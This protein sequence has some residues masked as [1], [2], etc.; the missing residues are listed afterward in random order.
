MTDTY[1]KGAQAVVGFAPET[2]W[3][4]AGTAF[5]KFGIPV[6]TITPT[7]TATVK[8]LNDMNSSR[9]GTAQT[10]T[11]Y[12]YEIT[13]SFYVNDY[14]GLLG[15]LGNVTKTGSSPF[16]YS[17]TPDD[18]CIPSFSLYNK[19][20]N[21]DVSKVITDIYVGCKI[22]TAN[23]SIN[24]GLLMCDLTF[25]AKDRLADQGEKVITENTAEIYKYADIVNGVI[26]IDSND[27]QID[28]W[29]ISIDNKIVERQAGLTI[30]E[31]SATNIEYSQAAA[32]Q[33]NSEDVKNLVGGSEVEMNTKFVRGVNDTLEFKT[34]VVIMSSEGQID[35]TSTVPINIAPS[36]RTLQI[37][38]VTTTDINVSDI[39]L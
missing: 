29:N 3:G 34:N 15:I 8:I 10:V 28:S 13:H 25:S 35:K 14:Y 9:E 1:Y 4:T 36:T 32:G 21:C 16:T 20:G 26:S 31:Q 18:K 33:M 22:K 39:K 19:I 12:K 17:F 27:V 23:F 2:T 7:K 37:D 24:E 30:D 6:G 11:A 38:Y 5:R